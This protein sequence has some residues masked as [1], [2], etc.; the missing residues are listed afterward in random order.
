MKIALWPGLGGEADS[1]APIE[2]RGP[3]L[4]VVTVDP[5]Y[6]SREDWRLETLAAELV[7]TGAD[8]Y[9]GASWGAAVAATAAALRP[10][11]AL[12]LLEGGFTQP[13][14]GDE[15]I[16]QTVAAAPEND[17]AYGEERLRAILGPFGEYDAEATLAKIAGRVPT[18][19]VASGQIEDRRELVEQRVAWA[20]VRFVPAGHDVVTELGPSLGALISDWLFAE[21]AV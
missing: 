6:G 13:P 18:F 14:E 11:T 5:R 10:P 8:V 3:N 16:A 21:V 2:L 7:E 4:E 9:G 20:D 19:V 1:F 15:W 17:W 12:V